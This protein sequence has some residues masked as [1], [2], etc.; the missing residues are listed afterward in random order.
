[1]PSSFVVFFVRFYKRMPSCVDQNV[2]LSEDEERGRRD[3][4]RRLREEKTK[5]TEKITNWNY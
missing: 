5:G 2:E 3:G 4:R 1:M